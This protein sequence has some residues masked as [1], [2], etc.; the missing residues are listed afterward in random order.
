MAQIIP[1]SPIDAPFGSYG[2]TDWYEK[3]RRAINNATATFTVAQG[4]TGITNYATGDL[5][6]AS[7]PTILSKLSDVAVGNALISGGVGAIPAWGKIDYNTHFTISS[8]NTGT[9]GA[10]TINKSAGRVNIAAAT[11]T[12]VVTNSLVTAASLVFC[13]IATADATATLKNV[14]SGAG[15]FTITMAA[16][17]TATTA[18]NFFVVN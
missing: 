3:V 11:P 1:P 6:Y 16:N 14:V 17:A 13:T 5:I 9:V 8:V 2:W 10:V 7:A 18:I 15:S 4:G 12:L